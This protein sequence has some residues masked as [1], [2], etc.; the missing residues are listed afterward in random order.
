MLFKEKNQELVPA[1]RGYIYEFIEKDGTHKN[2]IL[3]ISSEGRKYDKIISILML[4][5]NPAGY[6]V[7]SVKYNGRK[8]FVHRELVTYCR[9]D[10][11]G[12]KLCKVSDKVIREIEDGIIRGLGLTMA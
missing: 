10:R 4:S 6:D 12:K 5:D 9:R 3:V 8:R 7:V 2:D 1:E 11:L